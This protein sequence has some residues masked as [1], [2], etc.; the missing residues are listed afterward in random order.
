MSTRPRLAAFLVPMVAFVGLL[1]LNSLLKKL[2]NSFWLTSSEYWVYPLQTIVCGAF[3]TYYWRCYD[4][5]QPRRVW[6]AL[7][8]GL[9]VFLVW[10]APQTVLGFA[11]RNE[12]FDPT[13]F[14]HPGLYWTT[15]VFRFARLVIVVPL[16]EEI[17]WRG[18]LLRYFI[19][20]RFD[21]LEIGAWSWMSFIVVATAFAL[22]HSTAD[23][24]AAFVTG[25]IYNCVAY[26]TKSLGSCV[27]AHATTNLLLGIWIMSTRQ[28][29]FW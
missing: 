10:I 22:S 28:W 26:S 8:L 21:K 1:A 7:V 27:V 18:F 5:L 3:L 9:V 13:V 16:V 17:F 19:S 11:R 2:G 24:A 14:A 6:L 25:M 23:W 29:G 20:E 4:S 15:I 12:G